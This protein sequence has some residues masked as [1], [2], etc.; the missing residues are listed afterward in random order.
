MNPNKQLSHNYT[1]SYIMSGT[2]EVTELLTNSVTQIIAVL[3]H[4]QG[5]EARLSQDH[6]KSAKFVLEQKT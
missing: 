5:G 1:Y 6:F 2:Q 3:A 4:V